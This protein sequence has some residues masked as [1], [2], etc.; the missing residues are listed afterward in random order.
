MNLINPH[1]IGLKE[2]CIPGF[3]FVYIVCEIFS[4]GFNLIHFLAVC[5]WMIL[6]FFVILKITEKLLSKESVIFRI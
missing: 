2:L 1:N 6:Y 5:A 4:A 3:N